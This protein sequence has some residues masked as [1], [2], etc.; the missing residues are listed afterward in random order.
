M[1]KEIIELV[2]NLVRRPTS[3]RNGLA[4][5]D[6]KAHMTRLVVDGDIV[7][8]LWAV[9]LACTTP[10]AARATFV[11]PRNAEALRHQCGRD[12]SKRVVPPWSNDTRRGSVHNMVT[13]SDHAAGCH[14]SIPHKLR[15]RPGLSILTIHESYES[16]VVVR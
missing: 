9:T 13:V 11:V 6:A 8:L 7:A 5:S 15:P 12:G 16:L 4:G 3:P 1:R 10:R 14:L 2:E